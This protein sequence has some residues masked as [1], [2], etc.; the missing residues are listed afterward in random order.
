MAPKFSLLN[1]WFYWGSLEGYGKEL[2]I[3]KQSP[4]LIMSDTVR[5]WAC[6]A[7]GLLRTEGV[8]V[9]GREWGTCIFSS[10]EMGWGCSSV[11]RVPA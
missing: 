1:Q 10:A 3:K 8:G 6:K 5:V 7:G 4:N 11:G 2:L 9:L